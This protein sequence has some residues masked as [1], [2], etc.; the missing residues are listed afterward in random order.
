M[1][2]ERRLG[3]CIRCTSKSICLEALLEISQ[4]V[5]NRAFWN[6]LDLLCKKI[7][8]WWDLNPV[9]RW[10]ARQVYNQLS[11]TDRIL[12]SIFQGIL[13]LTYQTDKKTHKQTSPPNWTSAVLLQMVKTHLQ[14]N[15]VIHF[16]HWRKWLGPPCYPYPFALLA[17][18]AIHTKG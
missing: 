4:G 14:V 6:R 8:P 3:F 18:G 2:V 17:K 9:Q 10:C 15:L 12:T 11:C 7:H 16:V 1:T 5:Q 13:H